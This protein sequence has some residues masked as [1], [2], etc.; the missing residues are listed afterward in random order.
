MPHLIQT[1]SSPI[2]PVLDVAIGV[3]RPRQ[4]ALEKAKL[5]VPAFVSARLLVDTGATCTVLDKS[6]I[7]KLNLIP[8]GSALLHT[9]ATG[10]SGHP[11]NQFDVALMVIGTTDPGLIHVNH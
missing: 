5:P 9:S 6:V 3:S 4:A 10:V 8:T 1:M 2:G 11:S 7:R